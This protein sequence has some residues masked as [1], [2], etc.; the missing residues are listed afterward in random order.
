MEANN[1]IYITD[2]CM[3][4]EVFLVRPVDVSPYL[5][6]AEN[7]LIIDNQVKNMTR[8]ID[9]LNYKAKQGVQIYI[10]VYKEFSFSSNIN[11]AH[12]ENIFNKLNKNI[13]VSRYPSFWKSIWWTNHE[14]LVII[15]EVI[16]Y[17]GGLD[18]CWGRYDNNQHPIYEPINPQ[19]IYEFPLIDYSNARIKDFSKVENYHLESVPREQSTRMP[20][21]DVHSRIIGIV[22]QNIS[23]HFIERW[24]LANS[25]EKQ[26]R[27]L[28][29]IKN[30]SI[31]NL[32][33]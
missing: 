28:S 3:S 5:K 9:V 24:N 4:P 18:L 6:M 26:I 33:M 19:N 1:S 32:K 2:W 29:L 7:K 20:W 16:G 8:L 14:K 13:K 27:V 11:S 12:T 10:L 25:I 22:V 31:L 30:N 15:D 21:H 17:V 23:K